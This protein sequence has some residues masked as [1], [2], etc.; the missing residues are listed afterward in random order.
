MSETT[1]VN[2]KWNLHYEGKLRFMRIDT[3]F[4]EEWFYELAN[5]Y[6]RSAV[7]TSRPGPTLM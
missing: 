5:K 6:G 4:Q 7:I 3:N 1:N 2:S